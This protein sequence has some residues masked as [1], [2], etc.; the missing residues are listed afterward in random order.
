MLVCGRKR[1]LSKITTAK[2]VLIDIGYL[3]FLNQTFENSRFG[4]SVLSEIEN[5]FIYQIVFFFNIN[6]LNILTIVKS[7]QSNRLNS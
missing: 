7:Q 1:E 3:K 5:L 4:G 6:K 2:L